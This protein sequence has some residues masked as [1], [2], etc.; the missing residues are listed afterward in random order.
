MFR[1]SFQR[2][3]P[4]ETERPL[5]LLSAGPRVNLTNDTNG[6]T[7]LH[8]SYPRV[9]SALKVLLFARFLG[10]HLQFVRPGTSCGCSRVS[11]LSIVLRGDNSNKFVFCF[12]LFL[13]IHV[14]PG[15]FVVFVVV[16]NWFLINV[17][18]YGDQMKF[19]LR[20]S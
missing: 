20:P 9:I 18:Q 8:N 3:W 10:L 11:L 2:N 6:V 19:V 1:F 5:T 7:G 4:S 13:Q 16:L 17:N 14:G 12:V 15:I